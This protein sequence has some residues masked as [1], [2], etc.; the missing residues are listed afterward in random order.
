MKK[1][2]ARIKHMDC[3]AIRALSK[4]TGVSF[5]TIYRIK[6]GM[7]TKPR[8]DVVAVLLRATR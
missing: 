7:V 6:K 5:S 2:Q 3:P 8:G 1:L 4:K